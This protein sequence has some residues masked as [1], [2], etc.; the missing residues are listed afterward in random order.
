VSK[1]CSVCSAHCAYLNVADGGQS[2]YYAESLQRLPNPDPNAPEPS[3]LKLNYE[4]TY[5]VLSIT[6]T[7]FYGKLEYHAKLRSRALAMY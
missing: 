6:A 7:V 5:V 3:A 2:T 1:P 4:V